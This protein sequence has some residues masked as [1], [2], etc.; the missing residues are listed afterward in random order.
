[1]T[2]KEGTSRHS[3]PLSRI[4]RSNLKVYFNMRV[5]T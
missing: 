5:D 1:M 3:P 2:P 4:S